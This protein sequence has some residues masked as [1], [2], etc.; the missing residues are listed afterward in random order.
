M[1]KTSLESLITRERRLGFA[2]DRIDVVTDQR[3][4]EV[5]AGLPSSLDC[6]IED[7][8]GP[9]RAEVSDEPVNR[10]DPLLRFLAVEISVKHQVLTSGFLFF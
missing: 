10:F 8:P 9:L 3:R 4:P 7:P 1:T 5:N 6:S 2:R